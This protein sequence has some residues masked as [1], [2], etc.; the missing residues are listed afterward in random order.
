MLYVS[1]RDPFPMCSLYYDIGNPLI[2][3]VYLYRDAK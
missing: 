1:L 3:M 2:K